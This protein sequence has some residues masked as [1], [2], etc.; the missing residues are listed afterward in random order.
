MNNPARENR[1]GSDTVSRVL[2][3]A[4]ELFATCGYDAVSISTIAEKANVSKANIFHH[5]QSKRSLYI[6]V[7]QEAAQHSSNLL[8]GLEDTEFGFTDR[9]LDL[10]RGHLQNYLDNPQKSKLLLREI[11]DNTSDAEIRVLQEDFA[12][13]FSRVTTLIKKGQTAGEF[14]QDIDPAVVAI[15]ILAVNI[16]Y[17][18]TQSQMQKLADIDFAEEPERYSNQVMDLLL[19]GLLAPAAH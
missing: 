3:V 17:V 16:F 15:L 1:P 4:E 12:R 18:R 6:S 10:G 14:R 9:L 2:K 8:M 19:K 13:N 5:F 11:L 7:L